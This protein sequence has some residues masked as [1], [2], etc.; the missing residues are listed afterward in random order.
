MKILWLS[1]HNM[2][3]EQLNDLK[4]IYGEDIE[5]KH[6]T[7]PVKDWK[8]V[9]EIGSDCDVLAVVLPVN[10]LMQL[11]NNYNKKPI[12]RSITSRTETGKLITN[13]ATGQLEKEFM[14]VHAGWEQV[15]KIEIQTMKL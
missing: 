7:D 6:H 5:I 8:E 14:F 12:I 10:I 13:K 15:L 3:N 1:R 9:V 4:R 11:T 2:T